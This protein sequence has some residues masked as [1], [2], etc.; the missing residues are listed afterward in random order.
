MKNKTSKPCKKLTGR[1]PKDAED[2]RS[3]KVSATFTEAEY[4]EIK[5]KAKA[6]G[7]TIAEL[8]RVSVFRLTILE[9]LTE[10]ERETIREFM[11]QGKNLNLL[12]KAAL[13]NGW[14]SVKRKIDNFFAALEPIIEKLKLKNDSLL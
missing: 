5:N 8:L 2:K 12:T 6:A 9:R 4:S 10:F 14:M 7:L 11:Y 13:K 3:R 1:P